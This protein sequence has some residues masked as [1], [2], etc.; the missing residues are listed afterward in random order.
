MGG[1][2]TEEKTIADR[3]SMTKKKVL[4]NELKKMKVTS[5]QV[6]TWGF[7]KGRHEGAQITAARLLL[8]RSN[9]FYLSLLFAS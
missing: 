3:F 9:T 4:M 8:R 7:E 1:Q 6:D 2:E 5:V